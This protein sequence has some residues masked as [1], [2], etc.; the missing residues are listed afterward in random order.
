MDREF[1]AEGHIEKL[2]PFKMP[3]FTN[4]I[5]QLA[6]LADR[7]DR[8]E[9]RIAILELEKAALQEVILAGKRK[10]SGKYDFLSGHHLITQPGLLEQLQEK[11]K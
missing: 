8:L 4:Y 6:Q 11:E 2:S 1:N 10:R 3:L 5:I 9:T 7:N